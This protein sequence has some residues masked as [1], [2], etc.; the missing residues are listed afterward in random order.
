MNKLPEWAAEA[1]VIGEAVET[2]V[3]IAPVELV[4]RLAGDA[5]LPAKRGHLVPFEQSGNE[6]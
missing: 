3:A 1:A 5:E 4:A 6:P 2:D